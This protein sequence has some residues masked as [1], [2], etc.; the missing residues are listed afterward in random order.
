MILLSRFSDSQ[1]C[2]ADR[3]KT[4]IKTTFYKYFNE[5]RKEKE[6]LGG[7]LEWR[8]SAQRSAAQR[9]GVLFGHFSSSA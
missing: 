2:L 5:K 1:H 8:R 3:H 6:H 7:N 9:N 4:D